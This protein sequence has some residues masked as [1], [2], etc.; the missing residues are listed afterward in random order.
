M[1][2]VLVE[3][4]MKIDN[5]LIVVT[6]KNLL[7]LK[8]KKINFL[9]PMEKYSVG[10]SK[11]FSFEE[12]ETSNAFLFLNRILDKKTVL[13]LKKDLLCLKKNIVGICFT[14]LGIVNIVKELGLD[15][16]LI[17]MQNHN[18]TNAFSI[19]YYLE[20]VDSVFISTDITKE[21]IVTILDKASK[22]LVVPYFCLADAMYSRRTLLSNYEENFGY[23]KKQEEVLHEN[24]SNQDFLAI[25]NEYGTVLYAKKFIDYRDLKHENILY[26]Y[27]NP[28]GLNKL[29]VERILN[30]EDFSSI[31]D[32]G[33]LYKET[34]YRLKE[35]EE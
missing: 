6:D 21:E 2:L 28:L 10:F 25:E 35:G 34:Y 22:P 3:E 33:F 29:E 18:A 7:D 16:T 32:T 24:I 9:F 26:R 14:D 11:T 13:E 31:S 4:K 23:S 15:L 8:V 5:Y 1:E 30:G 17:Y 27:I 20:Y 12:I 19:N